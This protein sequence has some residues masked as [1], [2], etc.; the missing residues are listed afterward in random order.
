MLL[1]GATGFLGS[2]LCRSLL[3]R[4]IEKIYCLVRGRTPEGSQRRLHARLGLSS[5]E[6]ERI[7][8]VHGD[9]RLP[10][11]GLGA[12]AWNE[13]AHVIDAVYH[14]AASVNLA[15]G[16]DQLA[17]SNVVGTEQVLRFVQ[18]GPGKHLHHV[19]TVGIFIAAG[20]RPVTELHPPDWDTA[21]GIG[22]C[23]T[24]FAG[25][26]AIA[27]AGV[28]VTVYRPGLVLG[29]RASGECSSSDAVARMVRATAILGVGAATT[30]RVPIG[31][32]DFTAESIAALSLR[33]DAPGQIYHPFENSQFPLRQ[34]FDHL[35][36][37]GYSRDAVDVPTWHALMADQ[38]DSPAA[39]VMLAVWR[40]ARHVLAETP[41]LHPPHFHAEHTAA[42]VADE[43]VPAGDLD[44]AYFQ[45]MFTRLLPSGPAVAN[46]TSPTVT[47]RAAPSEVLP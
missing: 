18:T 36:Q 45:R 39:F 40:V 19:S 29:D 7:A 24:K 20:P 1:T 12:P 5:A 16:Y 6:R 34:M 27:A 13:L 37:L 22:Y 23:Q 17:P 15:A 42:A 10:D 3:D 41:A 21:G 47:Q 44:L 33:P 32:V 43:G 30:A 35:R 31:S 46:P 26:Q 2:R 4:P 8:V 28:P 25:E 38:P 14:C 11:F 9:V